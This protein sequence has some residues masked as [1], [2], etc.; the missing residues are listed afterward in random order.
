VLTVVTIACLIQLG[1]LQQGPA[2]AS[3]LSQVFAAPGQVFAQLTQRVVALYFGGAPLALAFS[4]DALISIGA[5]IVLLWLAITRRPPVDRAVWW[6]VS[7]GLVALLAASLYRGVPDAYVEYGDRY[8]FIPRVLLGWLLIWLAAGDTRW[9]YP[10]RL[11]AMLAVCAN[12]PDY[13]F[14][15]ATDYHW[16]QNCTPLRLG[17]PANIPIL[18]EG[19]ILQYPG[20]PPR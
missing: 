8:Y 2:N 14:P 17:Q 13:R 1:L 7:F 9:R 16:K 15:P 6:A 4:Q 3:A 5:A 11:V 20:R 10:A 19:W 12:L 18:P